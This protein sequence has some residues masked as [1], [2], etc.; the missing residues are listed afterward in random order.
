MNGE[1]TEYWLTFA[2]MC[3]VFYTAGGDGRSVLEDRWFAALSLKSSSELN[4]AGLLP[5]A[6]S[7]DAEELLSFVGPEQATLLFTSSQASDASRRVLV[8]AGFDIAETREPIMRL[9]EPPPPAESS[10][11]VT[12]AESSSDLERALHLSSQAHAVDETDL[13][14]SIGKAASRGIAS[15]FLAWDG[16]E[17]IST[18]WTVRLGAAFGVMEMM[19]PIEYQRR[20]AGRALLTAGLEQAW[21]EGA[22]ES[23]LLST[24][25]GRRLYESVGFVAVDEG[26]TCHRGMSGVV[27]QAIGQP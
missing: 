11:R 15:V 17:A 27:M 21:A 2:E 12:A 1:L 20:G 24:P 14:G 9:V 23:L 7:G 3:R 25:A 4:I 8:E 26:I 10:L 16:D 18:V 13:A 19:T 5:G 6:E 22:T